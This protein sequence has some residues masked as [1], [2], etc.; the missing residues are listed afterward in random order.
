MIAVDLSKRQALDANPR[1][2]QQ[3]I[4]Q[5]IWIEQAIQESFLFLKKQKKLF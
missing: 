1:K 3:L 4:L 2:I 5:Q